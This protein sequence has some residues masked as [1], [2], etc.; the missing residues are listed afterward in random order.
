VAITR[1]WGWSWR[2]FGKNRFK[3][4]RSQSF[5]LEPSCL[6]IGSG[7]KGITSLRPGQTI[8]APSI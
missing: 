7:I 1:R 8:A 6:K 2:N 3:A 4:L 5:L